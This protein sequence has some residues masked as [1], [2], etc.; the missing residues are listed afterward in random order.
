MF[1]PFSGVCVECDNSRLIVVKSGLCS[2]CNYDK[3][4]TAK[5]NRVPKIQ[6]L[7]LASQTKGE[8]KR[9]TQ[10]LRNKI[11]EIM[12][13]EKKKKLKS[14]P[15]LRSICDELFSLIVR[16]KHM[17]DKGICKCVT[18]GEPKH[19]KEIHNGHYIKRGKL[20]TRYHP[21]NG[22]PQCAGCNTYRD[23]AQDKYAIHLEDIYGYGVLQE[24]EQLSSQDNKLFKRA[25]FDE[26]LER[27][28]KEFSSI[29]QPHD[30]K[31]SRK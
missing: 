12:G 9:V 5:Q 29:K 11:D 10:Q 30:Y 26:T 17:D 20:W 21:K 31:G 1:R 13:R 23:G 16:W 6:H 7:N 8:R 2:E 19:W 14:L 27:L 18:C 15:R 24:L 25:E 28:Q 4:K 3:K 22:H